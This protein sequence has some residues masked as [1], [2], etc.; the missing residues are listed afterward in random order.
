VWIV[1]RACRLQEEPRHK[2]PLVILN[3]RVRAKP[4][5]IAFEPRPMKVG[6]EEEVPLPESI[7]SSLPSVAAYRLAKKNHRNLELSVVE[8]IVADTGCSSEDASRAL[9]AAK[10]AVAFCV[11]EINQCYGKRLKTHE[12]AREALRTRFPELSSSASEALFDY[13]EWCVAK[14]A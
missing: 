5:P 4:P 7:R 2:S 6:K 10:Q 8:L 11:S 1:S 3:D 14:G 13:S 9:E 12:P